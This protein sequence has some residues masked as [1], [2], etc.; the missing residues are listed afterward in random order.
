[1]TRPQKQ[2]FRLLTQAELNDPDFSRYHHDRRP[3]T[4][5]L[6]TK[7]YDLFQAIVKHHGTT[8]ATYLRAII[9]DVLAEEG[10][11]VKTLF[12]P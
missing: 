10:P 11:K 5:W 6:S 8:A 4:T 7:D 12:N 2:P 9:T 3:V 1:V